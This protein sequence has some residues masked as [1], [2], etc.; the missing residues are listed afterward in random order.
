[1]ASILVTELS[2]PKTV[3]IQINLPIC[4]REVYRDFSLILMHFD[5]ALRIVSG[6]Q[7]PESRRMRI[8]LFKINSM[9]HWQNISSQTTWNQSTGM[10]PRD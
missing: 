10:M 1:M 9:S 2:T 7:R 5:E 6:Y 4:E 8:S 3:V